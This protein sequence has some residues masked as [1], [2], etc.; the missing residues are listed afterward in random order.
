MVYNQSTF[1]GEPLNVVINRGHQYSKY[2][3]FR[4]RQGKAENPDQKSELALYP[5]FRS[6]GRVSKPLTFREVH[7]LND[8]LNDEE[9]KR[10]SSPI[11]QGGRQVG[12]R[13]NIGAVERFCYVVEARARK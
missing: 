1:N 9:S 2:V 4:V 11:T 5:Q 3:E 6:T 10:I 7:D 13:W 8:R 12:T